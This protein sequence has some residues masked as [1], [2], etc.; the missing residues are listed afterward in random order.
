MNRSMPRVSGARL[1]CGV[2]IALLTGC[3]KETGP[4]EVQ[5]ASVVV[6][7]GAVTLNSGETRQLSAQ[8][9][10]QQGN[11]LGRSFTW[12][13]GAEGVA[14]VSSTGLVTAMAAGSARITASTDGV[15]GGADIV[16]VAVVPRLRL[17]GV[18]LTQATQNADGSLPVVEGVATAVNVL[19]TATPAAPS[20]VPVVFRL[21]SGG[22]LVRA[23]TVRTGPLG[24]AAPDYDNPSAQILLPG[25]AITAGTEWDAVLD[26]A[27]TLPDHDPADN[28]LPASGSTALA[29]TSLS[30]LTI[31]F[32]PV[33]VLVPSASTG[34]V[35]AGNVEEYLETVRSILPTGPLA[36]TIGPEFT[37]GASFGS[38]PSGGAPAFWTQLLQ[39]LD[40]ARTLDATFA[41]H[42]WYGVVRPPAGFNFVVN[43]GWSFVPSNP[44]SAGPGTRTS[45]SVQVGWFNNPA[46][47]R[48]L[49]AHELSHTFGRTHAPS[50]G[51]DAP[52]PAFP[53]S[54]G[55]IGRAGHDVAAWARGAATR[56]ATIPATTGDVMGY[57]SPQWIGEYNWDAVR[58]WRQ[59]AGPVTAPPVVAPALVVA[60]LLAPDG[61]VT[62]RPAFSADV[63]VPPEPAVAPV[64]IRVLDAAGRLLLQRRVATARMA[65]G[66]G[67]VTFT[68]ILPLRPAEQA[69]VQEIVIEAGSRRAVLVAGPAPAGVT[70]TGQGGNRIEVRW[71]RGRAAVLRDAVA[72]TVLGF[73]WDGRA[74]VTAPRGISVA[75]SDGVRSVPARVVPR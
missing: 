22:M 28:R 63:P 62:V 73:G 41:T 40:L 72:G 74:V 30:T 54:T 39:E 60:G 7:P 5:V 17:V 69:N 4:S 35:G 21:T 18:Q 53:F 2:I 50:C 10:D 61:T 58:V 29:T 44:S 48:E 20:G 33:V 46:R 12:R 57:C 16:V 66:D 71:T 65:H 51:A 67:T 42:H 31:R 11:P 34:N 27:A 45:V 8:A 25:A 15:S 70:M 64:L 36:T 75:I 32:V 43:G 68:G 23:D 52:D 9:R 55:V 38:P 47:A 26:P 6:S 59:A 13:S 24:T 19:A 14:T 3:G 49:V 1:G 37:T 56:A